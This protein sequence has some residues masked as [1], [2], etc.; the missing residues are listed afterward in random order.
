MDSDNN[1][2]ERISKS[3]SSATREAIKNKFSFSEKYA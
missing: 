2:K 3:F 1:N